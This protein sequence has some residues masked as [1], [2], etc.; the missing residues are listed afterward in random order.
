MADACL[1]VTSPTLLSRLR[2]DPASEEAWNE[3]IEHYG[4]H[5]YRWCRQWG[6]QDADAEDVAQEILLKLAR[7]L[8]DFAYN[9]KSS[10]RGW[11][12]TVTHHAWR[13]FVDAQGRARAAGTDSNFDLL[14]S[15]A[16]RE[17]LVERLERAFDHELLEVAKTQVRLR[18]APR[19]WQAF[20]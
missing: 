20:Q 2:H 8:R 14:Q 17:D 3:F 16:A 13:D 9:P 7:K 6:L 10:F 15:I 1:P 18:V 12:K 19:T 11:L 5:I 4:P